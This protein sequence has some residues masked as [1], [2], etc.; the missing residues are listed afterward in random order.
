MLGGA[1]A[2]ALALPALAALPGSPSRAA[3]DAQAVALGFVNLF[4]DSCMLYLGQEQ[5]LDATLERNGFRIL[6]PDAAEEFLEGSSGIAWAAPKALGE[7][8]VALRDDGSCAVYA[9]HVRE[10]QVQTAFDGLARATASPVLPVVREPDRVIDTPS[11]PANYHSYL[12]GKPSS[13]S[14]IQ[15]TL[16]TTSSAMAHYQAV[17]TLS[18]VERP[19]GPSAAGQP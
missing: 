14:A 19:A 2:L 10:A 13:T 1:A 3:D 6:P 15:L 5:S 17:A 4:H 8:V 9:R 12:Q 11:G 16:S 18:L 7:L